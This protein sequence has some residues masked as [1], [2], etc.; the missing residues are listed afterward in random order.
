MKRH[1]PQMIAPCIS[2]S[3][4]ATGKCVQSLVF[5]NPWWNTAELLSM[6]MKTADLE[7]PGSFDVCSRFGFGELKRMNSQSD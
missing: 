6:E 7:W 2:D 1:W 3:C 5:W 4:H